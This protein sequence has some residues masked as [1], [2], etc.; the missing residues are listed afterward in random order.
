MTGRGPRRERSGEQLRSQAVAGRTRGEP[1]AVRSRRGSDDAGVPGCADRGRR[2]RRCRAARGTSATASST[3]APEVEEPVVP[4]G[5]RHR[6]LGPAQQRRGRRRRRRGPQG[7]R[8]GVRPG[9]GA[10]HRAARPRTSPTLV[11][12]VRRDGQIRET[13]L[14]MSRRGHARPRT[15]PPASRRSASRLVL[16]L[17]EDRTRERRVE[18]VRRDFVANVSHELKTPGRRDPAAGRG[19]PGRRRRPGGGASASPAGC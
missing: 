12:Q 15:S 19:G 4:P 9:A 1:A 13:E 16:A 10:R 11:R 14:L 8:A 6:A 2:R 5:R 7:L 18:A 3:R 17:V